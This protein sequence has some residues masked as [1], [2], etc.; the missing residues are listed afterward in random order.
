MLNKTCRNSQL[1]STNLTALSH[2]SSR[3]TIGRDKNIGSMSWENISPF[4]LHLFLRTSN[5]LR[6]LLRSNRS[7]T[8]LFIISFLSRTLDFS[9]FFLDLYANDFTVLA[10]QVLVQSSSSSKARRKRVMNQ[11][12]FDVPDPLVVHVL[13]LT[14]EF[15]YIRIFAS[16]SVT[17]NPSLRSVGPG[18]CMIVYWFYS[19]LQQETGT[20]ATFGRHVSNRLN[21]I[22]S[23]FS[24][25][26][27]SIDKCMGPIR[28]GG[29]GGSPGGG[30]SFWGGL[31]K[32]TGPLLG[33][34]KDIIGIFSS[35]PVDWDPF[36]VNWVKGGVCGHVL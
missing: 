27:L 16:L 18:K 29:G 24:N 32:F 20:N 31:Q 7:T 21:F 2:N 9:P 25:W 26:D 22:Y 6:Y 19:V 30:P 8:N 3:P 17:V 34:F 36:W 13:L 11:T 28:G 14:H 12:M 23:K 1:F 33:N 15:M 5:N 4:C 35:S 10:R